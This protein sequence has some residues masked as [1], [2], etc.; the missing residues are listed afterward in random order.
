MRI[1]CRVA[2]SGS[3]VAAPSEIYTRRGAEA[4]QH[5]LAAPRA[6]RRLP[7]HRRME[8]ESAH[9]E[10]AG[11]PYS[12]WWRR[13][14]GRPATVTGRWAGTASPRPTHQRR[15][16]DAAHQPCDG[17]GARRAA[18]P[19]PW[20][21]SGGTGGP[22]ATFSDDRSVTAG[23]PCCRSVSARAGEGTTAELVLAQLR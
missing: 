2:L 7:T 11:R 9:P 13:P 3:A 12:R 15:C 16:L 20:G 8:P 21:C 1:P 23:A 14:P 10:A 6:V 5:Q 18:L 19:H 4:V 17:S 22:A